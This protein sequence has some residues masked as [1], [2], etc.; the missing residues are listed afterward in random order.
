MTRA[1]RCFL[2]AVIAAAV[3]GLVAADV[4]ADGSVTI[5]PHMTGGQGRPPKN[6]VEYK[7]RNGDG[8]LVAR[9]WISPG[10]GQNTASVDLPPGDYTVETY[11]DEDDGG[12]IGGRAKVTV[13]EGARNG[14]QVELRRLTPP[15]DLQE[16]VE[17]LEDR[18]DDLEDQI[19]HLETDIAEHRRRGEEDAADQHQE[20]IDDLRE[21]IERKQRELRRK[22]AQLRALLHPANDDLP[23]A[24]IMRVPIRPSEGKY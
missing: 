14:L 11:S 6:D 24:P 21:N 15:E 17:D 9:G 12:R 18:I 23:D 4:R 13:R 2:G 8:D 10:D 22:R 3:L 1:K 20:Q 19:G 7:V 5:Q 16:Q